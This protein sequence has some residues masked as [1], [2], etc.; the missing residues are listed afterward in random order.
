MW[1]WSLSMSQSP[2]PFILQ[3]CIYCRRI[4]LTSASG[5]APHNGSYLGNCYSES[6]FTVHPDWENTSCGYKIQVLMDY[7]TSQCWQKVISVMN[8]KSTVLCLNKSQWLCFVHLTCERT[9]FGLSIISFVCL[10]FCSVYID[11]KKNFKPTFE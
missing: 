6:S 8:T 3:N 9:I 7:N 10:S 2:L 4:T 1:N 5:L 11:L